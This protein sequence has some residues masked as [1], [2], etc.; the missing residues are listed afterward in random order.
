MI[1][2]FCFPS[3]PV[4]L[5]EE[6]WPMWC[7]DFK[8]Q[9]QRRGV[10]LSDEQTKTLLLLDLELRLSSFEKQ[11]HDFGLQTPS[12]EDILQVSHVTNTQPAVIREELQFDF[13]DLKKDVAESVPTFTEE[14]ATVYNTIMDA[15]KNG[16]IL[17]VV[18]R[19]SSVQ[20][21]YS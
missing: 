1:L 20:S 6:F 3:S 7:D 8:L 10:V 12:P 18:L 9:S 21:F 2:M 16:G 15:V 13:E 19:Y 14:Q 5:F 11:L 17:I 4:A